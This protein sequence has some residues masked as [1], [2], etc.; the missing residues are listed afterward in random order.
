VRS[1]SRIRARFAVRSIEEHPRGR[2]VEL[3]ATV[4]REGGGK[5]VCVADLVLLLLP[6]HDAVG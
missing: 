4:E 1:G 3:R 6:D 5:P 2:R